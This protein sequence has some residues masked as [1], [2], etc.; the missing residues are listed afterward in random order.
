MRR[1]DNQNIMDATTL[2]QF[3]VFV[4]IV[5][6]GSFAAAARRM[7]RAQ[8]AITYAVQKLEDHSGVTLFDRASYRPTLTE[9]GHALLPRAR[10]IVDDVADYGLVAQ[11]I[12][13]GLE[14]EVSLVVDAMA[15]MGPVVGALKALHMTFPAVQVRV[16][17]ETLEAAVQALSEG[18]A[19][20]GIV[21]SLPHLGTDLDRKICGLVDL[22]PVASPE[23]PLARLDGPVTPDLLRDHVQLVLSGRSSLRDRKDYGVISVNR[24]Y[25]T[26]L[27]TKHAMLLAG[28]GWGTMP[29]HRVAADLAAGRL[30]AI[31]PTQWDGIDQMPRIP[32]VVAHRRK[33]PLGPAARW[34]V[35]QLAASAPQQA[36]LSPVKSPN[37]RDHRIGR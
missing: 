33:S 30:K 21:A 20:L 7:N 1:S 13:K 28:L 19:N 10:R 9:A 22:I 25:L 26:D 18:W 2:D 11:S 35:E 3:A 31:E 16:S 29:Q 5:E 34:L 6:A 24:W 12:A 15:P 17:I 32:F 23:H 4:A 14:A 8:S 37:P 36:A 27:E